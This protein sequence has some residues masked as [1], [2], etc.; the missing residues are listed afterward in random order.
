MDKII[1]QHLLVATRKDLEDYFSDVVPVTS[2]TNFRGP[3]SK[4]EIPTW[5][6]KEQLDEIE[7]RNPKA[8][9]VW[10]FIRRTLNNPDGTFNIEMG[11]RQEMVWIKESKHD[12]YIMKTIN[13]LLQFNDNSRVLEQ[14]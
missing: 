5:P 4:F 8:G 6:I 2:D 10:Y 3:H 13:D 12:P 7:K 1:K 11:F 14:K 9:F